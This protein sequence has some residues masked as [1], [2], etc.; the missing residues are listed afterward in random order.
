[1][2]NRKILLVVSLVLALAM[3]LTGTLAYLTDT[4]SEVNVM[5]LG[6]V[7]IEQ[8]EMKRADGIANDAELKE[9]NLVPFVD[10][11]KLYP[12][13]AADPAT[14][15]DASA[16]A[17]KWGPY[18][19]AED[20]EDYLFD[21]AKLVGAVDKIVTVENKGASDAY[22]R[23]L[24]A[25][26]MPDGMDN[27]IKILR[28][29]DDIDWVELG[30]IELDGTTYMVWS[31][32]YQQPLAAG[33]TSVPSLLQVALS[34]EAN[35]EDVAK[36][37]E[38]FEILALTQAVQVQNLESL[39][40]EKALNVAFNGGEDAIAP[41]T[42]VQWFSEA[43]G[44]PVTVVTD[45]DELAAA[46]AKGGT[47]LITEDVTVSETMKI[48]KG[49]SVD[50]VLADADL[51]FAV[52]NNGKAS[53]IINNAGELTLSGNGTL[54]FVAEDPDLSSIPAYATN[55][56]TNT[57]TLTIESGVTVENGSDGGASYAVDNHGVFYLNGGT[58]TAKRCALRVAKYNQ[59]NVLFE[60]NGG[61]VEGATPAWIQLPGSNA[62]DAPHI[63]VI[64]NDG[65][66]QTTKA[67]SY[68]NDILYTYSYGNSHANTSITINGG[69]FL[70][71]VVSV[72][73]GYKGDVATVTI[74]GGTF[75]YDVMQWLADGGTNVLYPANK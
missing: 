43:E 50:L 23:T 20:A 72:G 73:S 45:A 13:Y 74:N 60:M 65:T 28:H 40:P 75:E 18:V 10:G 48:A 44:L 3:T 25:I 21:D 59:D 11:I 57:G 22:V 12:A 1:M 30:K 33:E 8:H 38:T 39:A 66:F 54:T 32:T 69:E 2:K 7:D 9:G 14:A 37:G 24:L 71:G 41:A 62:S 47:V 51:N 29:N 52:D 19:S 34:H 4:D 16:S 58:L 35:N 49:T 31:A 56:I 67:S 55:T 70:G 53:A 63:T 46:L 61:L 17:I 64:I 6:N 68:D 15:Y 27:K 26:E 36:L 5:T 42:L